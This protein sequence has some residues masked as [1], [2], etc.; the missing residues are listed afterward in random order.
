MEH[1]VR[2]AYSNSFLW[3]TGCVF[4]FAMLLWFIW[5]R[6]FPE[7][8]AVRKIS[9]FVMVFGLVML[10]FCGYAS[11]AANGLDGVLC[12]S[13]RYSLHVTCT[14]YERNPLFFWILVVGFM[15]FFVALMLFALAFLVR[16][17]VPGE[18][19][20]APG[21]RDLSSSTGVDER[22]PSPKG[23][24]QGANRV[25]LI[26]FGVIVMSTLAWIVTR[27]HQADRVQRQV[28][29]VLASAAPEKAAVEAYLENHGVLPENN[30]AMGL[31]P[32][33]D[34]R[35]QYVSEVKIFKGSITLTFD[36]S[37]ANEHL[38]GRSVMLI[39]VRSGGRVSWPCASPDIDDKYLPGN[40]RA[41][42]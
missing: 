25:F 22:R 42:L 24:S 26:S 40:C 10:F 34:I 14:R 7:K 41:G 31:L 16:M 12:W 17:V 33:A 2:Q 29:E 18:Q 6:F 9:G 1:L 39:A 15:S 19:R 30:E 13:G 32:P 37:T 4:L 20:T 11:I 5:A 36:E 27:L 38:G 28:T 35:K 8:E 3:A 23:M 21:A